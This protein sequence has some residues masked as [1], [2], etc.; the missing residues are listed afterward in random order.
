[1]TIRINLVAG[2][3]AET[4]VPLGSAASQPGREGRYERR[5]EIAGGGDPGR[6]REQQRGEADED[7]DPE[8][9][10]TSP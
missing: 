5:L 3:G 6:S 7:R 10:P 4:G 1:M 8:S 2:K 9:S